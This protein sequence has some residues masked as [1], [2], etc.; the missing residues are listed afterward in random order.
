MN[1][2]FTL[3]EVV[4]SLLILS[5]ATLT[6]IAMQTGTLR[7]YISIRDND[8]AVQIAHRTADLFGIAA[9]QWRFDPSSGFNFGTDTYNGAAETPFDVPN[10]LGAIHATQWQWVT[11]FNA[12]VD[13]RMANITSG[14]NTYGGR[15]CVYA[16]GG[17][18]EGGLLVED[19][20]AGNI[21]NAAAYHVQILVLSSGP[22][23]A[24]RNCNA[25]PAG[26]TAADF[27]INNGTDRLG[28]NLE[29]EGLRPTY[30]ATNV[31][32]RGF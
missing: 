11:L 30:Y 19:D 24:L 13:S 27:D 25:L 3:L 17:P 16:R 32:R 26:L 15:H 18:F 10:P 1:K 23:G 31:Y 29:A 22:G 2:G 5:F 21:I 14:A 12:P 8:E 7:G 28:E 6:I 4:I 9:M 20:G